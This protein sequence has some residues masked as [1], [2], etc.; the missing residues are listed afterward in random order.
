MPL[1]L[2]LSRRSSGARCP[3]RL[4][5]AGVNFA[6]ALLP[7]AL[8]PAALLPVALSLATSGCG[9]ADG[10]SDVGASLGNADAALL[11]SPGRKLASGR[12]H[13]L[14]IDGSL[15]DGGHVVALRNNDDESQKLAIIP[16]LEGKPCFV[17]PAYAFDRLSSRIDVELSGIISLQESSDEAGRGKVRFL[18]FSCE[19]LFDGLANS[20]LPRVPFPASA[21]TG[22]LA[23][24]GDGKL[25]LIDARS[26][27]IQPVADGVSLARSAGDLLWTIENNKLVIRDVKFDVLGEIG[28]D[29]TEYATTGGEEITVAFQDKSGL[30]VWSKALGVTTLSATACGALAWGTD[31]IAYF[32]PCEE[33]RLNVYTLGERVGSDEDFVHIV[34]PKNAVFVERGIVYWGSGKRTSEIT[35][36][37]EGDSPDDAS[38]VVG[39]VPETLDKNAPSIELLTETLIESKAT[40]RQANIFANWDG[41]TGSLVEIERDDEGEISGL[42][43]IADGVVQLPAGSAYSHRGVLAHF[44]NGLGE[45]RVFEKDSSDSILVAS[46]VPLQNQTVEPD[47][48]RIA[49]VGDSQNGSSG[50]LYLTAALSAGGTSKKPQELDENVLVDTAR[51]LEQPRA[52]TYLARPPGT[53]FAEL[54]V[55]LIDSGLKLTIHKRVSEYRTVPWPAPGILYAVPEGKEQG[56]WFSK[57][58]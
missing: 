36:L 12:F 19:E 31:T 43:T 33:R 57:A 50:T 29:V 21:P 53:D 37:V 55:W 42:V 26:Q 48:G 47:S 25:S 45:L 27:T 39:R 58:R 23:L 56:L 41:I 11:D 44:E 49:F 17:E 20:T 32:D 3:D 2:N 28:D 13:S 52:L 6:A 4:T 1:F 24:E 54:R 16:Y 34:G 38:L 30:N 7:V 15:G 46:G 5:G 35:F 8:F 22:L 51:F 14:L 9:L 40:I 10:F 18:N